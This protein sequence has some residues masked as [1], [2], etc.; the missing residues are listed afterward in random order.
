MDHTPRTD[1]A[2]TIPNEPSN[3]ARIIAFMNQ[4]G[5]VGKTTAVVNIAAALAE[6]GKR[7]LVVDLDPQAHATLHLG[8]EAD[9]SS[10]QPPALY[11][12]LLAP[13]G[14]GED[15]VDAASVIV[16]ARPNLAL[17]PGST[18]QAAIEAELADA[19]RRHE[20]LAL[21]LAPVRSNYDYV[22]LDCPPSLGMLTLNGLAAAREIIVP[23]LA[24]FLA[25]QGVG[26]LLET[27]SLVAQGINQKL[28]VSGVLLSQHDENT[29]HAREVVADLSAFLR[30]SAQQD[31][32][33]AGASLIRPAIRRNIK[34]AEAPSFGQTI[35]EYE[36]T[37]KG[38]KD[39]QAVAQVLIDQW[40][41]YLERRAAAHSTVEPK[42]APETAA[43]PA[44]DA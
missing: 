19:P 12:L 34:L 13:S 20:R 39:F 2:T 5:G 11:D 23:M 28:R 18:D 30:D 44:T 22:L 15:P 24:H 42:A 37:C 27:V 14:L 32:P 43:Q 41:R 4:K 6:R 17:I 36:P 40:D 38:A 16:Q 29:N 8:I 7:V 3:P 33:W 25:L 35:F 10:E 21:A 1:A 9:E 26:K 31:V